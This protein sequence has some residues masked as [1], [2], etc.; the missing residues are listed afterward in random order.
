[1]SELTQAQLAQIK[2][3]LNQRYRALLEEVRDAL[4]NTGQQQYIEIIGNV[5]TD[6]GDASMG[7]ALAD[8]NVAMIDR[9][10]HE[11]R[12]IEAA[13][14]RIADNTFGECMDCGGEIAFE[15]LLA[16]PTAKRCFRCQ[17][18]YEKTHHGENRPSL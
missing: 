13:R 8:M 5:P 7:D 10:I 4:E 14:Q 1:M 9:Q 2:Q 3:V 12:D 18:Q 17:Q 15:R 11:L 16:Y 6:I